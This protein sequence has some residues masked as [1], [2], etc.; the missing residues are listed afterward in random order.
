MQIL[1]GTYLYRNVVIYLKFSFLG[2]PVFSLAT[3][4]EKSPLKGGW[5]FLVLINQEEGA[6]HLG[7]GP[8][9]LSLCTKVTP[10][11]V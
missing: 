10:L 7:E 4:L 2:H 6:S 1:R 11:L 8:G 9:K 5:A 3:R